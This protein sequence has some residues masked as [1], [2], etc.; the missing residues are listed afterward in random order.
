MPIHTYTVHILMRNYMQYS[1]TRTYCYTHILVR[2]LLFTAASFRSQLS[3]TNAVCTCTRPYAHASV[4]NSSFFSQ[5]ILLFTAHPSVHSC[6]QRILVAHFGE[7]AP[8]GCSAEYKVQGT[9]YKVQ[10]TRYKVQGITYKVQS[11]RYKVQGTKY[12]V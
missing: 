2:I 1:H 5:L 6:R 3:N 7:D 4:H 10:R 12:K 8:P 11:T 9:K